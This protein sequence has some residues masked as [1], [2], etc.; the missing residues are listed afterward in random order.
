MAIVQLKPIH[1]S[2][3][4][5]GMDMWWLLATALLLLP[6]V[7]RGQRIDRWE[8]GVLI[9]AYALYLGFLVR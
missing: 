2:T 5:G 6:V 7:W 9:S 3:A 1:F 4:L 8:G